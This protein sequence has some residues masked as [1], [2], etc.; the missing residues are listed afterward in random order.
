MLQQCLWLHTSLR[1][2]VLK[3]WFILVP[4]IHKQ[5]LA[6]YT[7]VKCRRERY[8]RCTHVKREIDAVGKWCEWQRV[9][10]SIWPVVR[11]SGQKK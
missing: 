10:T 2:C 3:A 1:N 9:R 11:H 7:E 8:N 4:F 5:A 6:V